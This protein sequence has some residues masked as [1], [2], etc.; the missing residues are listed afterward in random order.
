MK[1]DG[2]VD[3]EKNTFIRLRG[4]AW[5]VTEE[6]VTTFLHDCN[7]KDAVI[8]TNNR[9]GHSGEAFVHLNS[10][11]DV[12]KALVH[13]K[14]Y[15]KQRYVIIEEIYESQYVME[16]QSCGRDFQ[17]EIIKTVEKDVGFSK[18]NLE[19]S[20][21]EKAI[22]NDFYIKMRGLSIEATEE[23]IVKFL[24]DCEI[25]GN[26]FIVTNEAGRRNGDAVVK[27]LT[28]NDIE[29]AIEKK[30]IKF[31]DK[32]IGIEETDIDTYYRHVIKKSK[33][34]N[35]ENTFIRLRG[36]V[37]N[38]IED[39]IRTF[40]YDSKIKEVI[41]TTNAKGKP[42]GDALAHLETEADVEKAMS[43]NKE[44]LQKRYVVIEEIYES[45]FMRAKQRVAEKL[46]PVRQRGRVQAGASCYIKLSGLPWKAT[47][48][49]IA[50]F[51]VDCEL[52][53]EVFI[54]NNEAGKPTG[55]A[56]V[57]LVKHEDMDKAFKCNKKALLGRSVGIEETDEQFYRKHMK[58][59]GKVENEKN[60]FIRLR[61]LAWSV[62]EEDVTTFLHDCNVK[63]AIITTNNRGG[64]SGEAFIHLD[65][66]DDVDKA[67]LHNKEYLKQRYVIIEAIYESQY[68]METQSCE[69]N[70]GKRTNSIFEKDGKV[71][72]SNLKEDLLEEDPENEFFIKI[73]GLPI[74]AREEDIIEFFV[75][76]KIVGDVF[77]VT[78]EAGK[79]NGDAVARLLSRNDVEKAIEKKR[80]KFQDTFIGIEK[81]DIDTYYR[82]VKKKAK[83]ENEE[84]IFIRLRGLVWNAAEDDIR[85]FLH[86]SKIKDVILTTNAK[87][88]PS[89][90]ALVHLETEADTEKAMAHN[91]EF[92]QKRYVIIEEIYESQYMRAKLRVAGKTIQVKQTA[93][94]GSEQKDDDVHVA[95]KV[96]LV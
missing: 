73:R 25:V 12:D 96:K 72:K 4:L 24:V 40:L 54:I 9:G 29:K 76:C 78:N 7:V 41:L 37:W 83:H 60:T 61:G 39:D 90:E 10:E 5:S 45:Q 88:K 68:V 74:K 66:E 14:E 70:F 47:S 81:S 75:D 51:L 87:G 56:V 15:L 42:S 20:P 35:E 92:L 63:D 53:G 19:S 26:V 58:K 71:S 33:L 48:G 89:G 85:T 36:L 64:H 6:D 86:E 52:N 44:F 79:R 46:G 43:H 2:K 27:V 11:D 93:S 91:K 18:S 13:N 3:N 22:G 16:T 57:K 30:I 55:D 67:M 31:Q 28:R 69:R 1:K 82:H 32:F 65:S 77:I 49:D 38:A 23:D 59:V 95:K 21:I 34:E 50:E 94:E 17:K 84:N 8:T 62:T 80:N